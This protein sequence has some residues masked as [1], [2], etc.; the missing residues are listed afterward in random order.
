M[1]TREPPH[2]IALA[3]DDA[4]LRALLASALELV[5]YRVVP[6]GTGELLLDVVRRLRERGEPL[7]LIITDVRMPTIGGLEAARALRRAGHATPLI[8]MTA[9]G[10]AWTRRQAAELGAVLLDKPLSLSVLRQAVKRAIGP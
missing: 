1:D 7:R 3:E 2:L 8:F 9:F 6:V 4:A 5:G 10:D